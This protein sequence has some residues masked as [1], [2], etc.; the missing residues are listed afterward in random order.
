MRVWGCSADAECPSV[1]GWTAAAMQ[2][3]VTAASSLEALTLKVAAE[4][5]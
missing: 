4:G 5:W 2:V 3:Q 1:S